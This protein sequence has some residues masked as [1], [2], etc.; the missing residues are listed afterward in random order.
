MKVDGLPA[1]EQAI[2]ADITFNARK[3]GGRIFIPDLGNS[4]MLRYQF[5]TQLQ[6]EIL[7]LREYTAL[8]YYKLS[9]WI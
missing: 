9:G 7:I 5:W 4:I 1:F 6:Y 2:A 8:A 3:L